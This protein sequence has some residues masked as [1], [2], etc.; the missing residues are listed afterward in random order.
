MNRCFRL[1]L[2]ALVFS[3]F[4]ATTIKAEENAADKTVVMASKPL[5]LGECYHLALVQ[6]EFIAIDADKIKEAQAHFL[7]AL[8]IMMPHVAFFGQQDWEDTSSLGPS[9]GVAARSV[10]NRFNFTQTL[11]SGFKAF[12][13]M[14]GSGL[15]KEQREKEKRRAEELLLADVSDSFYL[16]IQVREDLKSYQ[17][18]H[19]VLVDR[20][21]ELDERE[22]LGKSRPSEVVTTRS[23]LYSVEADMELAKGNLELARQILEFLT[24][25]DIS[26]CVD[27]AKDELPTVGEKDSYISKATGRSD[28]IATQKAWGVAKQNIGVQES[29]YLPEVTT[30]GNYYTRRPSYIR[31]DQWDIYLR[32]KIPIFEGTEVFGAVKEARLQAHEAELEFQHTKRQAFLDIRDAYVRIETALPRTLALKKALEEAEKSYEL[33]KDEY[34][35]NLVNN[36]EVLDAIRTLEDTRRTFIAAFYETKRYFWQLKV[37]VGQIAE[38][39]LRNETV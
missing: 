36:L 7:Q 18:I 37:A 11:F 14:K 26:D 6:S 4:R 17:N 13:A 3:G 8:S 32:V 25:T 30:E 29:G 33:Q 12:G 5:T 15:E 28:V 31:K 10:E 20:I 38:D 35:M 39:E 27:S 2:I 34:K 22:R 1:L 24:G 23:Q 9:S 21:K 16:F 19:K